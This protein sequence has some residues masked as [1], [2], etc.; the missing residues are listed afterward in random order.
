MGVQLATQGQRPVQVIGHVNAGQQ[1]FRHLALDVITKQFALVTSAFHRGRAEQG[2]AAMGKVP[3]PIADL[4]EP[5]DGHRLNAVAQHRFQGLFPALIH[6]HLVR[7]ARLCVQFVAVEP[8]AHSAIV[9]HGGLLQ[10]L[11]R[12]AA[13]LQGLQLLAGFVQLPAPVAVFP[14]HAVDVFLQGFAAQFVFFRLATILFHLL[15]QLTHFLGQRAGIQGFLFFS[16]AL[17][18][19]F[20][21]ILGF[22]QVLNP[23]LLHFRLAAGFPGLAVEFLPLLLPVLHGF[24][25]QGQGFSGGFLLLADQL[26]LW[27]TLGE[28]GI[29]L[30]HL[31][32]VHAQMLI[33]FLPAGLD[34]VQLFI[35]LLL[36][37]ALVLNALLQTGHF[38]AQGVKV[39]LHLV[40]M[41]LHLVVLLAQA[42]HLR[43]HVT[44]LG[45]LGFHGHIQLADHEVELL[46]LTIQAFP[47]QGLELGALEALL[48]LVLLVLF[49]GAGLAAEALQLT[50]QLVTDISETLQVFPGA[51]DAVLGL[52]AAGL[53]LG[54]PRRFLDVNPQ[55]FRLGLDQPGNHAL[56]DD[57]VAARAQTGAQEDVGNIFAAALGAIEEIVGLAVPGHLPL[58]RDFVELAVFAGHRGVGVIE[59]QLDGSLGHG[60]AGIGAVEDHVGHGFA[61]Q[62]FGGGFP[63]HPANRINDIGLPTPVGPHHSGEIF[64]EIGG[65]RVHKG[66]EPGQFYGFQSHSVCLTRANR[67]KI[68]R[69]QGFRRPLK[70]LRRTVGIKRAK[71]SDNP[72]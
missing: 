9:A 72:G 67:P 10:G 23:G 44:L 29:Q 43:I 54:D 8:V 47:A 70:R 37:F 17:N 3:Q 25:R 21:A 22:L 14:T 19:L 7:Q 1:A 41:F 64:R 16:E 6:L 31:L 36:A 59:D 2:Q 63:H 24:F 49:R 66:F 38:R 40:E 18:T 69:E 15:F 52:A 61:T 11:Q 56:L 50:L 34:L 20:Q 68:G 48:F 27:L 35:E 42:L 71:S 28:D 5:A 53:V 33:G 65:G 12:G 62:V 39:L 60:L 4:V 58:H 46:D 26:Q 30:R 55:L 32:A 45:H 51:A 57:G 13:T